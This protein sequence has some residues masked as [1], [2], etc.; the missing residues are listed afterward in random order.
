MFSGPNII[1]HEHLYSFVLELI[2]REL[3]ETNIPEI[4]YMKSLEKLLCQKEREQQMERKV[5]ERKKR[6]EKGSKVKKNGNRA[7]ENRKGNKS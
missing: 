7:F 1:S 5:C 2:S 4:E 3:G 6:G